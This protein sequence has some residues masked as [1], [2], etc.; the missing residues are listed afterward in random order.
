M[1]P[2]GVGRHFT[3]RITRSFKNVLGK[4]PFVLR[5]EVFKGKSEEI[6]KKQQNEK[7]EYLPDS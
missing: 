4:C 2:D 3:R 7:D 5:V 6:E 1:L